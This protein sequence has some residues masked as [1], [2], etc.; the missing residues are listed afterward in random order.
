MRVMYPC[1]TSY[2]WMT[3]DNFGYWCTILKQCLLLIIAAYIRLA[4]PSVYWILPPLPTSHHR[5]I[6]IPHAQCCAWDCMGSRLRSSWQQL[7]P[8]SH[9][10]Y[11][12]LWATMW[13]LGIELRTPGSAVIVL[14]CWAI[15]P[16]PGPIF[17]ITAFSCGTQDSSFSTVNLVMSLFLIIFKDQHGNS[18]TSNSS[19]LCLDNA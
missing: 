19:P 10:H 12:W 9:P 4:S 3:E 2:V 11:R 17:L 13:L 18:T 8:L 15:S 16:A 14:D 7:Y 6:G 5:N 1:P